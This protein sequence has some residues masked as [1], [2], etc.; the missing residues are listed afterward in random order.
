M[1]QELESDDV[2]PL[3]EFPNYEAIGKIMIVID[4]I[5]FGVVQR[6]LTGVPQNM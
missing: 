2:H 1:V 4:A 3:V 6:S 5:L